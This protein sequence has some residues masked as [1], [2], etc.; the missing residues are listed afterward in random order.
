MN[1]LATVSSASLSALAA[2]AGEHASM[3][4]GHARAR[5]VERQATARRDPSPV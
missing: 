3:R 2:A 1:P 5:G 4:G